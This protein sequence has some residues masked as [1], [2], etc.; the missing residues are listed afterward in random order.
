MIQLQEAVD[1]IIKHHAL[2]MFGGLIICNRDEQ[3]VIFNRNG[4]I[5]SGLIKNKKV[6][7]GFVPGT[8]IDAD[9]FCCRSKSGADHQRPYF[10]NGIGCYPANC[11]F[12]CVERQE[13][14][15]G[16]SGRNDKEQAVSDRDCMLFG[17]WLL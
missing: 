13:Y 16:S 12:L 5:D 6:D 14:G 4:S 2:S 8:V 3:A 10:E 11:S 9:R 17:D 15:C 1:A 7:W